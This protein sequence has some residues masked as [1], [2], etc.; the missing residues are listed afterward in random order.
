MAFFESYFW[1]FNKTHEKIIAIF[2]ISAIMAS[3]WNVFIKFRWHDEKLTGVVARGLIIFVKRNPN[4]ICSFCR[5]DWFEKSD[6]ILMIFYIPEISWSRQTLWWLKEYKRIPWQSRWHSPS[7]GL[8]HSVFHHSNLQASHSTQKRVVNKL[9][10][11]TSIL[12]RSSREQ[13]WPSSFW[14]VLYY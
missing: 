1:P 8:I 12:K 5:N 2:V 11:I 10:K 14:H 6:R 13:N 3:I 9:D 7:F 4:L